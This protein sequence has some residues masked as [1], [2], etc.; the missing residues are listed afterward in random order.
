ML[1]RRLYHEW[2]LL[3]S[4]S[5]L[6]TGAI[7]C[8]FIAEAD[9]YMASMSG[10]TTTAPPPLPPGGEGGAGGGGAAVTPPAAGRRRRRRDRRLAAAA[11]DAAVDTDVYRI[12]FDGRRPTHVA[13]GAAP[14]RRRRCRRCVP[15]TPIPAAQLSLSPSHNSTPSRCCRIRQRVSS[16]LDERVFPSGPMLT[17]ATGVFR[18]AKDSRAPS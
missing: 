5:R 18:P 11:V 8:A 2:P 13:P 3:S 1:S 9:A 10:G 17:R 16:K 15:R 6:T 14:R 7:I 4:S 12:A